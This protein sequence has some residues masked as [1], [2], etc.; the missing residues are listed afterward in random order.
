MSDRGEE[1]TSY[2]L[3]VY[4]CKL[5]PSYIAAYYDDLRVSVDQLRLDLYEFFGIFPL[6]N[7]VD[8]L[9]LSFDDILP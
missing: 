1:G 2:P 5:D 8:S 6:K 4:L 7:S 9:L 3:E